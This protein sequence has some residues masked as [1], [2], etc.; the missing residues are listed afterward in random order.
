M[1]K[2]LIEALEDLEESKGISKAVILE[3]L[4]KALEKSYEKN[5]NDNTNVSVHINDNNGDI[6]VYAL[7]TVVDEVEDKYSQISLEEAKTVRKT[8]A[9]DDVVQVEVKPKNFGRVAAQT[10]R[11]IVIQKLRDAERESIYDEYIN[12]VKEMITG[13]VQRVDYNNIY[14]NLGMTDGVVPQSEQIPGETYEA[15]DRIKLYVAEV[16]NNTKGPQVLLSRANHNLVIR[17]FEQEVPEIADGTVEIFSIAREAG[18]RSKLA[19]FSNDPNVDPIGACVGYKGNRVN[20]IVDE[21][22]GEKMDIVIYDKDSSVFISNALS[23]SKVNK[24][25]IN[26]PD[27]SAIIV[28]PDDQLS[29]AIGKEGQN[30]RLAAKLTGWKIDI[31]GQSQYEESQEEYDATESYFDDAQEDDL[32]SDNEVDEV[33]LFAMPDD[34]EAGIASEDD[35]DEEDDADS[36]TDDDQYEDDNFSDEDDF[37]DQ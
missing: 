5:F 2:K 37:E 7:K 4:E 16:R 24:V 13:T 11:N 18:S 36:F 20:V 32:T 21:L 23:P 25:I 28:V 10:A 31:K 12:R 34:Y 1:N 26:E 3:A 29:L 17:L 33:D 35:Y 8:V 19:V 15:G 9:I 30:V 6:K 22:S 27:H 14:I